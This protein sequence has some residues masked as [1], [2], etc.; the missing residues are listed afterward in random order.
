MNSSVALL[1]SVL[2]AVFAFLDVH[3]QVDADAT[4]KTKALYTNLKVIQ[5]SKNILFGQEFFNS[6]RYSSGSAHGDKDFS[7]SKEITGSHPAVLGSDFHYYLEKSA[8]EKSFH[9][10]AVKWAF[11]LGHVITFDWHLSARGTNSYQYAGSP[12]DLVNNIVADL[13][14][15]R[16]W[17]LGELDKVITIINQDLKNGNDTIPIVFRPFHEM[18]GNWFWWGNAAT[19]AANYRALYA[20]TVDYVKDRTKSVLFCWSPNLPLDFNYYPGDEYVDL[21][22]LDYYEINAATLRTQLGS[23]VDFA[24]QHDKIAVLSET[25][26]R[27]T[28]DNASL[29]WNET[30]LPAILNDP[31]EKA[32]K[33]GWLLTWINASWSFPYVPHASS[34]QTAKNSFIQFKESPYI[35]FGN[36]LPAMYG[37]D[38]VTAVALE[39]ETYQVALHPVPASTDLTIEL[40]GYHDEV[41][42]VIF[43]MLGREV[44]AIYHLTDKVIH[45]EV[46]SFAPGFYSIMVTDRRNTIRKR[47]LVE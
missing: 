4:A 42:L 16:S 9:T 47:F 24:E 36:E 12:P 26:N 43:D 5:D 46:D 38:P 34:S 31:A 7:D 11:Q 17:F 44:S 10:E 37:E 28:G 40:L 29:Y 21:V 1:V 32:W 14:G 13:N 15:D 33:I 41:S 8:L 20:L 18:N 30:V 45:Q 3:A 27:V 35:I 39:Q 2:I 19:S 6:F 23:L 22:G 25:G